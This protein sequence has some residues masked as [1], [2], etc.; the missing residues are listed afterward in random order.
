MSNTSNT[1]QSMTAGFLICTGSEK[2]SFKALKLGLR[3]SKRKVRIFFAKKKA[4]TIQEI[5]GMPFGRKKAPA[6]GTSQTSAGVIR[7]F[8]L[9]LHLS[10]IADVKVWYFF[11]GALTCCRFVQKLKRVDRGR[12]CSSASMGIVC[13]LQTGILVFAVILLLTDGNLAS[14]LPTR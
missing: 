10:V 11:V 3:L 14:N 13:T 7:L 4:E 12:T 2:R 8:N 1:K 6:G 5:Q 9:D